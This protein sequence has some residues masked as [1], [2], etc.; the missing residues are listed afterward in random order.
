MKSKLE[1]SLGLKRTEIE[2]I[3]AYIRWAEESG[4]YWKPR[5]QFMNRHKNIKRAFEMDN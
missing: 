3:K 4:V 5:E 1:I 2:Q